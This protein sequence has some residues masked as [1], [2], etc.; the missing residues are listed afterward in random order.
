MRIHFSPPGF[1]GQHCP[2]E[3][4]QPRRQLPLVVHSHPCNPCPSTLTGPRLPPFAFPPCRTAATLCSFPA[5]GTPVQATSCPSHPCPPS[6]RSTCVRCCPKSALPQIPAGKP[7]WEVHVLCC[8][9]EGACTVLCTCLAACASCG[10]ACIKVFFSD[11]WCVKLTCV[12]RC[13]HASISLYVCASLFVCVCVRVSGC[14]YTPAHAR[15]RL[16]WCLL[17]YVPSAY[18]QA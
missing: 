11:V 13:A 18:A 9:L 2:R 15:M 10:R 7:S 6:S 12:L 3:D 5:L 17:V 14:V 4:V 1:C 8:V 16:C